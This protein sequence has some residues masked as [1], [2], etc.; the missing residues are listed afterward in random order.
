MMPSV[1]GVTSSRTMLLLLVEQRGALDRGAERDD[2][3]GVHALARLDAEEPRDLLLDARHAR[4]AAD[5][6]D[7][8]DVTLVEARLSRVISQISIVPRRDPR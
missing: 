7:L 5:E 2:L 6:H 3:V 4:H 1:W 8:F